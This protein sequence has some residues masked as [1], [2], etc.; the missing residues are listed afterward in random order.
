[1]ADKAQL[2]LSQPGLSVNGLL[3]EFRETGRAADGMKPGLK[4]VH[5]TIPTLSNRKDDK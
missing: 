5:V 4:P 2:P 3:T 1:M